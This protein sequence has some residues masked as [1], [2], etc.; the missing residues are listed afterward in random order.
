MFLIGGATVHAEPVFI[1][2]GNDY[3][4]NIEGRQAT[5]PAGLHAEGDGTCTELQTPV[6]IDLT[7][8][9]G[10]PQTVDIVPPGGSAQTIDVNPA[11]PGATPQTVSVT[12]DG[13]TVSTT[14]PV[15]ITTAA[16]LQAYIFDP[17]APKEVKIAAIE[18]RI[19]DLLM[20]IIKILVAQIEAA[21]NQGNGGQ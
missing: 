18:S 16:E 20:E 7:P 4:S 11:S 10:V 15:K 2:W 1:D 13:I 5:V 14:T 17:S 8:P 9:G 21:Q 6:T 19:K 12:S 3:C